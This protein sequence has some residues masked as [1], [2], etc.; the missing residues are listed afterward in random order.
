MDVLASELSEEE[1]TER[2]EA[3]TQTID[4]NSIRLRNSWKTVLGF[5]RTQI[6]EVSEFVSELEA[7][8]W[9]SKGDPVNYFDTVVSPDKLASKL[10]NLR[11]SIESFHESRTE[12]KEVQDELGDNTE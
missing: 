10:G 12:K 1:A 8:D 4:H 9:D 3:L 5:L 2:E 6:T 11:S 7:G